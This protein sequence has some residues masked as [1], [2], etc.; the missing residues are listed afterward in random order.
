MRNK[1]FLSLNICL[2]I[3]SSP[4]LFSQKVEEIKK[5]FPGFD[6][7]VLNHS[8]HYKIKVENGEPKAESREVQ[9]LYYLSPHAGSYM[10]QYSFVHSSFHQIQEYAAYTK[11]P[12]SRKVKVTDFKTRDNQSQNIFYDDVKETSFD[13]PAI[14]SG[15]TGTLELSL[16]HKDA[17]L[18]SPFYFRRRVPVLNSELR[19]TFPKDMSIK[20]IL[21]GK[22]TSN[23]RFRSETKRGETTYI[24]SGTDLEAEKSYAD[25]PDNSYYS[26]HVV[27]YIENYKNE[28]KETISYLSGI[29]D[30]YA[31]NS[32]FIQSINK[33]VEPH[34]KNLVDSLT[35]KSKNKQETARNI[36]NWVQQNIKYVAFEEGME[37]F[38][39]RDANLVCS[40]RFGDC[41]DMSSIL[42]VMLNTAGIPAYYTWIGTRDLP[43]K[44]SE[45]PTPIVDNHMICTI[46]L[47]GEYIFLDG[48]DPTCVFGMPSEGIQGKE[49]LLAIDGKQHKILKVPVPDKDQNI[50]VDST[51]L[52]LTDKEISGSI[53]I[54]YSGYFSMNLHSFLMYT[55]ERDKEKNLRGQFARG[56]NKFNLIDFKT[57]DLS[58][59]NHF[60]LSAT[61]SLQDYARKVSDE[62]YLNLNLFKF[63]EHEH[64]DYPRRTMPV[65]LPFHFKKRYITILHI[66]AGYTVGYLPKAKSYKNDIWGYEMKYEHIGNTV[67]LTQEFINEHL[68]IYPSQFQQWNKVLESLIPNY[69]ESISLIKK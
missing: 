3:L 22:D 37:G 63:Y 28:K 51:I 44:Y 29:S 46:L 34:L 61:F 19:I 40:R 48:T 41:K 25:A 10:S 58:D 14:A 6:V 65:E 36:Y 33:T 39:P 4:N 24:F 15:A 50:L 53:G 23:I 32:S 45:T 11:T 66:P 60:R 12:D 5:R 38:I 47:D 2:C 54:N 35:A 69:N 49:A 20:Y 8:I 17:H 55:S 62:Y 30:L 7:V 16:S 42:T 43:Y 52:T 1:Y 9:Q 57:G 26:A 13:F 59:K 27:F 31:L 67:I 64:I 68:L 18:L 21:K 56:S